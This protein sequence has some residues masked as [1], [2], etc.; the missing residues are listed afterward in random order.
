MVHGCFLVRLGCVVAVLTAACSEAQLSGPGG[1]PGATAPER[2]DGAFP[3]AGTGVSL[4]DSATMSASPDAAAAQCAAETHKAEIA[5]LDLMLL[6]DS[7]GSMSGA[8][9]MRSKWQTAQAALSS[10]ISDP[11][12]GG[13]N[14]GLQFFPPYT[15]C[16]S[17]GDCLDGASDLGLLCSGRRVCA[18]ADAA[19]TTQRCGPPTLIMIGQPYPPC[20]GGTT[21]QPLGT[22][23]GNGQPCAGA[24]QPCPMGGGVCEVTPKS[25]ILGGGGHDCEDARYETPA[26]TI[27]A[28]PMAERSLIRTLGQKLPIGGTPLGPAVRG[29]LAHLRARLMAD[30]SR[31]AALVVTTDGLP[32]GC[33]RNDIA[34]VAEDVAAA[35]KGSLSLPTYVIGVFSANEVAMARPQLDTLAKSGGTNQAFVL[36]A[37]EDLNMHLLDALN[38]IRGAALACE[39]RIPAMPAGNL[40][41]G[42]VNVRHLGPAGP[43]NVPYVETMSRCDPARGGWYYDAVPPAGK[44]SR[45]IVCPA[46][47]ASF[48]AEKSAQVELVFGCATQGID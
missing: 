20:P 41:F 7:S 32:E 26:V 6:L 31:K 10:F 35:F 45:I 1:K 14:V 2:P 17:D 34:A 11:K 13:L 19:P 15:T 30:P 18:S 3:G 39:Y 43:E 29:V 37:G 21:C 46:T 33:Q 44:P 5:P 40:D 24:G 47:C 25:C 36:T 48:N 28:L 9:G 42:K 8:A 16:T 23:T 38:Q 4:P 27:Q 12:S 22:C